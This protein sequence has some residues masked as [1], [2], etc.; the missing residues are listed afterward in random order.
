MTTHTLRQVFG[1]VSDLRFLISAVLIVSGVSLLSLLDQPKIA[2]YASRQR[3]RRFGTLSHTCIITFRGC[4]I[5][6]LRTY[7]PINQ[8]VLNLDSLGNAVRHQGS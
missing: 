5:Y 4:L 8:W 3:V 1:N 6:Q 7:V 2:G